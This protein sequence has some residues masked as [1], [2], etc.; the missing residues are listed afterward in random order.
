MASRLLKSI[1]TTLLSCSLLATL[2]IADAGEM[3]ASDL[4]DID[5]DTC[6]GL[7]LDALYRRTVDLAAG[8]LNDLEMLLDDET[9]VNL[10][11]EYTSDIAWNT[12]MAFGVSDLEQE[13]ERDRG[14][15]A[16]TPAPKRLKKT[17]HYT[18]DDLGKLDM[19]WEALDGTH[20]FLRQP[21]DD[22]PELYCSQRAFTEVAIAAQVHEGHPTVLTVQG[23]CEYYF[24]ANK[25]HWKWQPLTQCLQMMSPL[26]IPDGLPILAES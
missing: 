20:T 4:F 16:E 1:I 22:K 24:Y 26:R 8:C 15:N 10:D 11:E 3:R 25:G 19:A 6:S 23:A 9:G 21:G 17:Y 13:R 18:A 7:N 14:L 5:I 12:R 2:A